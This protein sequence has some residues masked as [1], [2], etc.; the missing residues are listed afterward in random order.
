MRKILLVFSC[1]LG[2]LASKATE[3]IVNSPVSLS[4]EYSLAA[5]GD[6]LKFTANIVVT[7]TFTIS[8]SIVIMGQGYTLSV[9][10]YGITDGGAVNSSPSNFRPITISGSN[11]HIRINDLKIKGG[12]T[13]QGGCIY[14]PST[15]TLTLRGCTISNGR[16]TSSAGGLYSAG[17]C[18]IER[19]VI[20]RNAAGYGGGFV[21]DGSSSHMFIENSTITENRSLS[22]SGGGGGG[23]TNNTAKLYI[24]NC[25]FSSNQSTEL[26]GGLSIYFASTA[27][28]VNSSFT[29]NVT[30]SNTYKGGGIQA[31]SSSSQLKLINCLFAYNYSKSAGSTG[32]PTA[33]TSFAFDDMHAYN[34]ATIEL[35]YSTYIAQNLTGSGTITNVIGNTARGSLAAN[36]SDNDMF[37][38]GVYTNMMGTDGAVYGTGKYFQP[39]LINSNGMPQATL[40]TGSYAKGEGTATRFARTGVTARIAYYNKST[41]TW[42]DLTGTTSGADLVATDQGNLARPALPA[43]PAIG[44]VEREVDNYYVLKVFA[45][46]NGTVNGASAYGDLYASGDNVRFSALPNNGYAFSNFTSV[47]GSSGTISSNP[48]TVT[49]TENKSFNMNFTSTTNFTIT[50]LANEATSGS[51]PSP[52]SQSYASGTSVAIAGNTGALAKTSFTFAGWNTQPNGSGTDYA[53]DGSASY[54]SSSAQ[55]LTLY[56]KWQST[57]VPLVTLPVRLVDYQVQKLNQTSALI[58]WTV[59][60]NDN[61]DYFELQRSADGVSFEKIGTV[62]SRRSLARESYQYQDNQPLN[63]R[64]YYRLLAVLDDGR[65]EYYPVKILQFGDISTKLFT[66]VFPNPLRGEELQIEIIDDQVRGLLPYFITDMS[67]RIVQKG[68]LAN[69]QVNKIRLQSVLPGNYLLTVPL[70]DGRPAITHKIVK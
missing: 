2:G 49:M 42:V 57:G 17:V 13:T 11:L 37:T 55:N 3:R 15:D 63:G 60:D 33:P 48:A 24:N 50:Y 5:A 32:T 12:S 36:G 61:C 7:S 25:T 69:Q 51:V 21:T 40:Q 53:A 6:T 54:S 9:P 62:T 45:S 70:G 30:Y 65:K 56:A 39:F 52:A 43:F 23:S 14:M 38:G 16:G 4:T 46:A 19:S 35:Y 64:N 41:S 18:F 27:Y 26:G 59:A 67:G 34:S 44:A 20:K 22:T 47:E 68:Y 31:N 8:K 58:K 28:V 66:R 10:N 1:L 29:G